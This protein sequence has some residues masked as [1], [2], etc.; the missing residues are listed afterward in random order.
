M[1]EA[2]HSGLVR[3]ASK[4]VRRAGRDD[5]VDS[6]RSATGYRGLIEGSVALRLPGRS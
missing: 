5:S 1:S 4:A 3:G 2:S 6:H